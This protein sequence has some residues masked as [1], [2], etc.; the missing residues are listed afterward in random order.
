MS[1]DRGVT[2]SGRGDLL[3][4][5]LA[6]D[7]EGNAVGGGV[8]ELEGGGRE[9]VEILVQE[10]HDGANESRPRSADANQRRS[11]KCALFS[12]SRL[13]RLSHPLCRKSCV[14]AKLGE[15]GGIA[16]APREAYIVGRLG[17]VGEG[18]N[19]HD[20]GLSLGW[21]ENM[22][23]GRMDEDDGRTN[24]RMAN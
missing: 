18:R 2:H 11:I 6:S 3:V 7:L 19:R 12:V 5:G 21:D 17:N 16:G 20:C 23:K 1:D 10:L 4:A 13:R 14:L 9:V 22:G 8:L 24:G 15:R